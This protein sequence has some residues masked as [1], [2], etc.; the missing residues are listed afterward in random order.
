MFLLSK[1]NQKDLSVLRRRITSE[2]HDPYCSRDGD[3]LK[4]MPLRLD[5]LCGQRVR[6]HV[7]IQWDN[8]RII[9]GSISATSQIPMDSYRQRDLGGTFAGATT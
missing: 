9:S 3:I 1:F 5:N 6:K 4:S 8:G 2:C 7:E